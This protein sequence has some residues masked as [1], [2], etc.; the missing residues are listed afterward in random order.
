M[1]VHIRLHVLLLIIPWG[2]VS[3]SCGVLPATETSVDVGEVQTSV[4]ITMLAEITSSAPAAT[5]APVFTV[6]PTSTDVAP[7]DYPAVVASRFQVLQA[8]F[9]EFIEIHNELT[10]NPNMS[11]NMDW[12]SQAV[13]ALVRVTNVAAEIARMNSY[14]PEYEGFHQHMQSVAAEGNLLFS[15]YMLALD[16][17]DLNAQ[18]QATANLSKMI[19]S[20]NAAF[21]ELNRL[22]PAGIPTPVVVPSPTS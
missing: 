15:N 13:A 10:T 17:Q 2:I 11:R 6:A 5:P 7:A 3:T 21:A 12:Y 4:F 18:N 16:N 20:L 9:V 14:P 22:L 1:N 19:T 8:A